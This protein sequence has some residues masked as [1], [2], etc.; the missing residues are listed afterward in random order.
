[1]QSPDTGGMVG[2]GLVGGFNVYSVC[3]SEF[4]FCLLTGR[5]ILGL[6]MVLC[7]NCRCECSDEVKPKG[8]LSNEDVDRAVKAR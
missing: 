5:A 2:Y 6:Q 3:I 4:N 8:L 7:W 1:M